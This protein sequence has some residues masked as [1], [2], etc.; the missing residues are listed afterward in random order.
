MLKQTGLAHTTTFATFSMTRLPEVS[1]GEFE[2]TML[3]E[4]LPATDY[5]LNRVT[6]VIGQE[7]R[8]VVDDDGGAYQWVIIWN[9]VRANERVADGSMVIYDNVKDVIERV[10]TRTGLSL[11]TLEARWQI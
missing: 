6:N 1:D 7:F 3:T 4:V 11:A 10:G 5:P 8:K 2:R 9:G